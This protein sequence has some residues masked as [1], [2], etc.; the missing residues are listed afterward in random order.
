[1][2]AVSSLL[3]FTVG[4]LVPLLPWFFGRG[5]AAA[6]TSVVLAVVATVVVGALIARSTDRPWPV[7]VGRQLAFTLLP[8]ALTYA[9]GS[10][11]GVSAI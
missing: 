3:A 4:A 5:T 11:I 2:A 9:I 7:A 10:A 1:M 6:V 8:A